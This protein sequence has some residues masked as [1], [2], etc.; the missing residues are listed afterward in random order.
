MS[1]LSLPTPD[2]E[3]ISPSLTEKLAPELWLPQLSKA[4]EPRCRGWRWNSVFR[5]L[6]GGLL[7]RLREHAVTRMVGDVVRDFVGHVSVQVIG[8]VLGRALQCG[9]ECLGHWLK[10]EG[11]KIAIQCCFG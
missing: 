4:S 2:P 1:R 7:Q 9:L 5:V 11:V 6:R 3:K 10:E 8:D